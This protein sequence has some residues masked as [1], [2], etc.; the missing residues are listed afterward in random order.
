M[1]VIKKIDISSSGINA[2]ILINITIIAENQQL[3]KITIINP[4][5]ITIN[6][7]TQTISSNTI[8]S[9][10]HPTF[11]CI[12]SIT[13]I[14]TINHHPSYITKTITFIVIQIPPTDQ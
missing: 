8:T 13:T 9:N 5:S 14:T 10:S 4:H 12:H 7:H 11:T 2:R 1:L 6:Y 3:T